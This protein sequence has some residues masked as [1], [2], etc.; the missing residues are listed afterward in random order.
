[1][2]LVLG[3]DWWVVA[4]VCWLAAALALV[5]VAVALR[6]SAQAWVAWA[7][8]GTGALALAVLA[9]AQFATGSCDRALAAPTGVWGS[10]STCGGPDVLHLLVII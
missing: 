2:S 6:R 10:S 1:M 8:C 7:A 9:F 5:L 3:D 4:V